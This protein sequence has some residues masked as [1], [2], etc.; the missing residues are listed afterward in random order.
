MKSSIQKQVA[1][2]I[3]AGLMSL[4]AS[5]MAQSQSSGGPPNEYAPTTNPSVNTHLGNRGYNNTPNAGQNEQRFP[6]EAAPANRQKKSAKHKS[7]K[8]SKHRTQQSQGNQGTQTNNP[9]Y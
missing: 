9:G 8:S 6:D 4:T 5:A 1:A 2:V 7:G 3:T